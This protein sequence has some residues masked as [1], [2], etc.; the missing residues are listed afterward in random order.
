MA[1][2]AR[3]RPEQERRDQPNAP[4]RASSNARACRDVRIGISGW[5]YPPWRGVFYPT[6]L[7]QRRELEFASRRLRTVEINGSFYSLQRPSSYAAWYAA[8]PADFVFAVKGGRFITHNKK[9]RDCDVALANF[10]ASGVL[11]LDDKLGPVLWQLPPQLGFDADRLETFLA[12]LPRTTADA[13]ELARHHDARLAH[14]SWLDVRVCRPIRHALEVR[15]ES[16]DDPAFIRLLRREKVALC[17]A[18]TAGTW[19]YFEDVTADF[20][21][22]RLHGSRRLYTSGYSRL[23]LDRW[24]ERVTAWRRG[25]EPADAALAAPDG[26]TRTA[27]GRDVYVYFDNDA[28]ARAPFDAMNL[29]AR[30]GHGARVDAP[31]ARERDAAR[32]RRVA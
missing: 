18:D 7:P 29:A 27:G 6:G 3:S 2:R 14:G 15:H 13:A 17:V 26:P 1:R 23:E 10:F 16:F 8:T 5:R 4:R 30:L 12:S 28:N 21:Y 24:A 22:V 25:E 19:P 31:H 20:V 11:A 9:L 32:R